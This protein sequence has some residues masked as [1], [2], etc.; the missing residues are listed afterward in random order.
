MDG[1]NSSWIV[2][3]DAEV[4]DGEGAAEVG[5]Y[6]VAKSAQRDRSGSDAFGGATGVKSAPYRVCQLE[7]ALGEKWVVWRGGWWVVVR[8]GVVWCGVVWCG[9]VWW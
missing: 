1:S 6:G 8:C 9:V 2:G 3:D 7:T 4:Y 5:V